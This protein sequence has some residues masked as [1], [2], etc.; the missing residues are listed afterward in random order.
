MK[1]IG[2]DLFR[3]LKEKWGQHFSSLISEKVAVVPGDISFEDL[4]IEDSDL[5]EQIWSQTNAI[6]NLAATTKFDERYVSNN[7]S[8]IH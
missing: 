4:G 8:L 2:K 3:V 7:N 6:I 5:R 1:I